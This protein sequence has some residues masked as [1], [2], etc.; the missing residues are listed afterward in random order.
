MADPYVVLENG[1]ILWNRAA[2]KDWFCS[3]GLYS[4]MFEMQAANYR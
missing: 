1:H 4:E 2:M 3:V